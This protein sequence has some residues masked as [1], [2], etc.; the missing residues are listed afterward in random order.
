MG[1]Y[2]V[3]WKLNP[4]LEREEAE[5]EALQAGLIERIEAYPYIH[6][7]DFEFVYFIST[8]L[9]AGQVNIDLHQGLDPDDK[10][11]VAQV[12]EGSYCGWLPQPV[13]DWVEERL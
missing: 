1:V 8:P 11:V 3:T 5:V 9:R 6:D 12:M 2:L 13:W 7:E 4:E 10:I